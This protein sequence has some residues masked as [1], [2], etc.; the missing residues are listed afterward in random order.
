MSAGFMSIEPLLVARIGQTVKVPSL[1]VITASEL[2]GVKENAQPV[3]AVHVIYDGFTVHEDKGLVEIVERWLTVVAVR[4]LKTARSGEDVR[5]DAGQIL[6]ALFESLLGWQADGVKPLL[7][8]NPPRPGFNAGYGYF[9]LAWSARLKK[10]SMPCPA[11][12]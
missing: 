12:Q 10:I 9:P 11:Y 2:A 6:A 7:P 4:N 3:P 8:T 1:K 5:Q